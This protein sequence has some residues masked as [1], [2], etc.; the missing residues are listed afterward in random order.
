MEL[1]T[2][3]LEIWDGLTC[4][5]HGRSGLILAE[6]FFGHYLVN[7]K[8]NLDPVPCRILDLTLSSFV[9]PVLKAGAIRTSWIVDGDF[10]FFVSER[11]AY[12]M[13]LCHLKEDEM[14]P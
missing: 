7:R 13:K 2:L 10:H 6:V 11:I 12:T 3:H 14:T 4:L 5:L 1:F 9:Q 8:Y